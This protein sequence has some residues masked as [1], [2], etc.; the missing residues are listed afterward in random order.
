MFSG[1]DLADCSLARGGGPVISSAGP[2]IPSLTSQAYVTSEAGSW[3][4][5]AIIPTITN[6]MPIVVTSAGG[7]LRPPSPSE[8]P[9]KLQLVPISQGPAQSE[10]ETDSHSLQQPPQ[11]TSGAAYDSLPYTVTINNQPFLI[12][13]GPTVSSEG[14]HNVVLPD[15]DILTP[16]GSA[17]INN[18][19]L[20]M[21]SGGSV[22]VI[23]GT[24]TVAINSLPSVNLNPPLEVGGQ[25]LSPIVMPGGTTAYAL[26]P[27]T[28]LIPG[29][30]MTLAGITLSLPVTASG[31]VVVINGQSTTIG[32]NGIP[33]TATP[34]TTSTEASFSLQQATTENSNAY[35]ASSA[36]HTAAAASVLHISR[37][38][39]KVVVLVVCVIVG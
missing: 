11:T 35:A 34:S 25:T 13:P 5:L 27:G 24:S 26:E 29:A 33:L 39:E 22:I 15:G 4:T 19:M 17:E 23:D 12:T 30:A 16:G 8:K 7:P 1:S 10:V 21:P 2:S 3:T 20:S 31:S 32:S 18:V 9:S 38:L 28:T 36:T 37:L 14:N 6:R